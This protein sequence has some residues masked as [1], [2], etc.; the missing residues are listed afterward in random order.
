MSQANNMLL[1][2]QDLRVAFRT[3]KANGVVQRFE[4]VGRGNNGVRDR[5][6]VV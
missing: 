2:I 3:G 5:K 1:S 4:A 6:S